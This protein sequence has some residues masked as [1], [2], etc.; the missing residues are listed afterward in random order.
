MS[1]DP[2]FT[3]ALQNRIQ[4]V[5]TSAEGQ[6]AAGKQLKSAFLDSQ[7]SGI[8]NYLVNIPKESLFIYFCVFLVA[9]FVINEIKFTSK[10]IIILVASGII[11][12]LMNEKRRS[13]SVTRMQE[14]ELKLNSIFP[15]PKYFYVDAGIIEL[16][17]SIREYKNYNPLAFNKL[18]R[19]LDDFLEITLDIEKN[20]QNAF[21]LYE[22][23]QN[24]KD[25][26][27]NTLHSI[28]YN[29]PSDISV[30]IKLDDALDSLQYMLNFHLEQIRMMANIKFK[31]DGPNITNR[32]INSN[33]APEGRDPLFNKHYDLF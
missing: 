31:E 20:G 12:F 5:R 2:A 30:S 19:S 28:I 25:A 17:H 13:T 10:H 29:S 23:L 9:F 15:K 18:I 32:Y 1:N 22:T 4:A 11:I 6:E 14:L 24:M 27:L 16:I 33:E 21:Q 3:Q 8:Y 26:I 7:Q